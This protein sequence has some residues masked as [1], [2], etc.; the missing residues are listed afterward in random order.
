MRYLMV[1]MA[2]LHTTVAPS[3][4]GSSGD[5]GDGGGSCI[6][7]RLEVHWREPFTL[8]KCTT[9]LL[10]AFRC[11]PLVRHE[12]LCAVAAEHGIEQPDFGDTVARLSQPNSGFSELC[13]MSD[14]ARREVS[15]GKY[16]ERE[17]S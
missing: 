7:S 6:E 15:W 8:Q 10:H 2:L 13:M 17:R 12:Q 4:G 16:A 9:A 3:G 11:A 14:T 1:R 5:G